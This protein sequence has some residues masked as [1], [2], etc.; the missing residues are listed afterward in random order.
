[1]NFPPPPPPPP[2]ASAGRSFGPV[3]ASPRSHRGHSHHNARGHGP[4]STGP[5]GNFY[6]SAN[7]SRGQGPVPGVSFS[8]GRSYGPGSEF[9]QLRQ[10]PGSAYDPRNGFDQNRGRFPQSSSR[11]PKGQNAPG[12]MYNL[13]MI[14]PI[15]F[16]QLHIHY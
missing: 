2:Q 9:P 15:L 13:G 6:Q 7:S 10:S 1:M 8:Q 14:C 12:S 4:R 3:R 11:M 16:Y 5:Q